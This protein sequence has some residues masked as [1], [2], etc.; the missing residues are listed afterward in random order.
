[1]FFLYVLNLVLL[2]QS[3]QTE[4]S[5]RHDHATT[6][7]A[8]CLQGVVWSGHK[9]SLV[10]MAC[11]SRHASS[12]EE[13]QQPVCMHLSKISDEVEKR[14]KKPTQSQKVLP[15]L[16]KLRSFSIIRKLRRQN[17]FH[18]L[19]IRRQ[20]KSPSNR[21]RLD[22]IRKLSPILPSSIPTTTR[23]LS[24]H[25]PPI[26]MSPMFTQIPQHLQQHSN[27]KWRVRA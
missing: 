16:P 20:D 13:A 12:V 1:M 26:L 7:F 9:R 2:N 23:S 18:I 10:S 8:V 4:S 11:R 6:R 22:G 5:Q 24:K 19:L 25:F 14:K 17:R 27:I 21:N 15:L 3:S